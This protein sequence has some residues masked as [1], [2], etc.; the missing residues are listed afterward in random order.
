M[1]PITDTDLANL[2]LDA[3]G[4]RST[5]ANFSEASAEAT[6]ISR[7]YPVARNA[8]LRAAHWDFARKQAPLSLL[9]D[10]TQGD[11]V[12]SPWLY[13]YAPPND[14]IRM[15]YILPLY[16]AVG[17][18]VPGN[19]PTP[20]T[21][22]F[23]GP[24]VRFVVSSDADVN[25]NDQTVVLCSQPS[26]QLVYT[27][28]ITNPNLYDSLFIQAFVAY[29]ASLICEPLT[30]SGAKVNRLQ[31]AAQAAVLSARAANG[32]EGITIDEHT[33]AWIAA[34]GYLSDWGWPQNSIWM[35]Q[36]ENLVMVS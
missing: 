12:P 6:C 22:Q 18:T 17:T 14:C 28:L 33:P 11:A 3:V 15:R 25:G 32:N 34:R 35:C 10:A 23:M 24:V 19:I 21:P 2:A 26:A 9:L 31:Q 29:L 20:I 4:T 27:K 30:G 8:I 13:E 7:Q 1:G 36:P 5:I 16:S